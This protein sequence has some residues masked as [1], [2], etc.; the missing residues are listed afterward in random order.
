[1]ETTG[2][3]SRIAASSLRCAPRGAPPASSTRIEE[4]AVAL[5]AAVEA[6]VL[7]G[8]L[9]AAVARALA[10]IAPGPFAVR[11]SMPGEDSA[12]RSFAG[13]FDTYLFQRDA[14]EVAESIVRCWGSA[15][16]ARSIAYRLRIGGPLEGAA[17]A[18]VVQRMIGGR[19]CRA[20]RSRRTR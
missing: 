6:T 15:F 9:A 18:V 4:V 17:M 5:R 13:Q 2:L 8:D 11:S 1:M 14:R 7:D 19:V 16:T 3:A 10:Q 12:E 20:L